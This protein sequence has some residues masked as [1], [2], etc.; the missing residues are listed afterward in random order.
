M[1]HAHGK[2]GDVGYVQAEGGRVSVRTGHS[3]GSRGT[4]VSEVRWHK[5]TP[6]VGALVVD[7]PLSKTSLGAHLV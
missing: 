2:T 3:E 5:L 6:K 4:V 7:P 1:T